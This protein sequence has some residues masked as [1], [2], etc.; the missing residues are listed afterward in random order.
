[1]AKEK[2]KEPFPSIVDVDEL[3][4]VDF[5]QEEDE[6]DQEYGLQLAE[7]HVN[8]LYFS[9]CLRVTLQN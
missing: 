7:A 8:Y 3:K 6:F 4:G 9:R 2:L 5:E 1:M